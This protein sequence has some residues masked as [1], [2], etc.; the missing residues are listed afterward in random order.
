MYLNEIDVD[1]ICIMHTRIKDILNCLKELKKV[2]GGLIGVYPNSSSY[3]NS[4]NLESTE[5][6]LNKSCKKKNL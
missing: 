1:A 3:N 5:W 6:A 4:K 2:W